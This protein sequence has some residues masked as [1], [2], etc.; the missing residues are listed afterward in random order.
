ME[1]AQAL[2]QTLTLTYTKYRS[3]CPLNYV[4]VTYATGVKWLKKKA[5]MRITAFW[6]PCTAIKKR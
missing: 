3:K 1:L 2:A 4:I 5:I 6:G